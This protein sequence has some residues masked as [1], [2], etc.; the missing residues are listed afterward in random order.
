VDARQAAS[1]RRDLIGPKSLARNLPPRREWE[2]GEQARV[3]LQNRP[4]VRQGNGEA[5]GDAS[6]PRPADGPV[7]PC[8]AGTVWAAVGAEGIR[9]APRLDKDRP[10]DGSRCGDGRAQNG[11]EPPG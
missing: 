1:R 2:Q 4:A 11:A 9:T 6:R 8:D 5:D 3:P 10:V 7:L